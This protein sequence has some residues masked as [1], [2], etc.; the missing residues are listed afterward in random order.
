MHGP[1]ALRYAPDSLAGGGGLNHAP[2]D[3]IRHSTPGLGAGPEAKPQIR[4]FEQSLPAGLH[5]NNWK[6]KP[7]PTGT[8][9]VHVRTFHCKL[10]GDCLE[11]LDR[12]VN[13][14]LDAH[15][16]YEV[17]LVTSTVGDWTGKLKEPNLILQ[18]WV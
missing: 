12:Q 15:P 5:E 10:T 1:V 17:K 9:A 11:N 13:E 3:G 2:P 8:G 6:R 18:V 4:T 16:D 14:W 7:N